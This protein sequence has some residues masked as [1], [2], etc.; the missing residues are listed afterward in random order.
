MHWL[1][2]SCAMQSWIGYW[3]GLTISAIARP[4]DSF[5]WALLQLNMYM[6]KRQ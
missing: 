6:K 3:A 4:M 5:R 1:N 2:S